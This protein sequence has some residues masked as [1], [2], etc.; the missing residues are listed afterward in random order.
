MPF[1]LIEGGFQAAG[2][3]GVVALPDQPFVLPFSQF[4][5]VETA[6]GDVLT[7]RGNNERT[8]AYIQPGLN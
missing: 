5:P 6:P 3:E 4:P 1:S 2:A 8:S 7:E